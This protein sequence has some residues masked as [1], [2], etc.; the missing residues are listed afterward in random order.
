MSSSLACLRVAFPQV[1]EEEDVGMMP[2][3]MWTPQTATCKC[4]WEAIMCRREEQWGKLLAVNLAFLA[5]HLL[6]V[7]VHHVGLG[8][9]CWQGQVSHHTQVNLLRAQGVSRF[10]SLTRQHWLPQPAASLWQ[11]QFSLFSG[12]EVMTRLKV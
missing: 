11:N 12:L 9:F 10:R 1:E 2:R 7:G 6:P 5:P 3:G 8:W 4:R